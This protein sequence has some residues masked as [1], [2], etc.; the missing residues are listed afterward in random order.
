MFLFLWYASACNPT[1]GGD[2][3]IQQFLPQTNVAC[4]EEDKMLTS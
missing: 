3:F 4:M 1:I 2:A